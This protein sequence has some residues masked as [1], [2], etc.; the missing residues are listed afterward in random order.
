MV[1]KSSSFED[2]ARFRP[3]TY[4]RTQQSPSPLWV[5]IKHK[6]LLPH[7]K[8]RKEILTFGKIEALLP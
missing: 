3:H 1:N 2:I 7:I 8:M 4:A 5:A 6:N